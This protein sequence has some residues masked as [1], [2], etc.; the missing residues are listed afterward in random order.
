MMFDGME[1]VLEGGPT[2][3]IQAENHELLRVLGLGLLGVGTRRQ[4]W[5]NT[6]MELGGEKSE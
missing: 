2:R 1:I 4:S 6:L 5:Q 3:V